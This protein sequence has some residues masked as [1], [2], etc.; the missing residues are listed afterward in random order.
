MET[1]KIKEIF[2]IGSSLDDLKDSPES[3]KDDVGY[4]LHEAQVGEMPAK[5]KGHPS[6]VLYT[7]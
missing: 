1:K 4:S 6:K 5:G 7:F 3:V 2:W